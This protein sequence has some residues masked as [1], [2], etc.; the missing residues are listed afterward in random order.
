MITQE[1]DNFI[2]YMQ[3]TKKTSVNT[4]K[5]YQRDLNKMALYLEEQCVE[6]E[7]NVTEAE[8][9]HYLVSMEEGGFAPSSVSRSVA[10]MKAFYGYL[11]REQKIHRDPAYLLKPPK[12]KKKIPGILS[13]SDMNLLL[14]Q[15]KKHTAK[16]KRDK[17]ML[18]LLYA[19]GI[20]VSELISLKVEDLNLP[21][22][23]L[24][25]K[26]NDKERKIPFGSSSKTALQEYLESGR[27]SL[28]CENS[29]E[30]VFINCSGK[31]MSR[32]GVWKVVKYYG[33]QAG[34][35]SEITP[36]TFRHSFAA[37]LVE[38]G[39]DVKTVQEMMGHA[40]S[41]SMQIYLNL[42]NQRIQQVYKKSHPRN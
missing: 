6:E 2:L 10:S 37:H 24:V 14:D 31:A 36:H 5:S 16:G 17:A 23:Y 13:V 41:S 26:E 32:Q 3:D 30:E 40:D 33:N 35:K 28:L 42:N 27:Q 7:E 15:P 21:M 11:L 12:I 19:T 29:S 39:A 22:N 18:E 34:I 9:N 1:I 20:R 8:L 25:C 4:Q 38:N